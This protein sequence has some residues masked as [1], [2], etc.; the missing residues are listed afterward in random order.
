[1][2][3]SRKGLSRFDA[4]KV[5]GNVVCQISVLADAQSGSHHSKTLISCQDLKKTLTFGHIWTMCWQCL[6]SKAL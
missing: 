2:C 1:M 5:L 6:D 4:V 3:R